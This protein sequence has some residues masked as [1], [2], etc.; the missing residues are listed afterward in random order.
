MYFGS[1]VNYRQVNATFMGIQDR[2]YYRDE[3]EGSGY[4]RLGARIAQSAVAMLI[5]ANVAVFVVDLFVGQHSGYVMSL[6]QLDGDALLKPWKWWQLITYG[7]AHSPIGSKLGIWHILFNMFGLFVFGRQVEQRYGKAEFLRFYLLAIV[8]AGLCWAATALL[9]HKP[10]SVLGASGAVVAVVMLFVF[11]FPRQTVLLLG[12]FPMQAWVLGVVFVVLEFLNSLDPQSQ[13]AWQAHLGGALF[14]AMYFKLNWNFAFLGRLKPRRS[15]LRVHRSPED[16]LKLEADR[17]L[18]KI[19]SQGE[20]SLTRRE[21]KTLERYSR[22][23][24]QRR[25]I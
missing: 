14:A 7:F 10:E 18:E 5:I 9:S 23:M 22:L 17:L 3:S 13:T 1:A 4:R 8:F 11:N 15:R 21:R 20:A 2:G 24:R 12:V 25:D 19:H 6:L 16:Q